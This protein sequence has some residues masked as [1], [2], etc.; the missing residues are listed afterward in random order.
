MHPALAILTVD[1]SGGDTCHAR[2]ERDT[3]PHLAVERG[4]GGEVEPIRDETRDQIHLALERLLRTDRLQTGTTDQFR[5]L[6]VAG[7]GPS[8]RFPLFI[9]ESIVTHLARLL[10][11]LGQPLSLLF[12]HCRHSFFLLYS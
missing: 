9:V 10:G 7:G 12:S 5:Q 6:S 11:L 3:G 8:N 2:L 1:E 4:V